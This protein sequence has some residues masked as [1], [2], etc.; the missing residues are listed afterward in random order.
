[1]DLSRRSLLATL[2]AAAPLVAVPRIAF[3]R[4]ETDQR[5]VLIILRG[6][7]DG[8]GAVPPVGDPHYR[9]ARGELAQQGPAMIDGMFAFHPALEQTAAMVSAGEGLVV[10]AV[11]SPYRDRSHF[12]GQNVLE[13]GGTSPYEYKDGW[14]NRLLPLLPAGA[15]ALAVAPAVPPVL[16]GRVGVESYAPSKL[17]DPTQD[18]LDRVALLYRDDAQLHALWDRAIAA[19]TTAQGIDGMKGMSAG[20]GANALPG[21]AKIAAEFL[22]RPGGVRV[23]VME[24][25]GWDTH[26]GQAGRLANQL[27]QLDQC[28]AALKAGLGPAWANTVVVAATEFGRTVQVNGTGGT[29]HGTASAAFVLGGAVKGGHVLAD[30][31]GLAQSARFEGRDLKPTTDLRALLLAASAKHL[32]IDPTRAARALFP[33]APGLKPAPV[34][35]AG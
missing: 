19:R 23:A 1:M 33:E 4:A 14:L 3:A 12:D 27:R 24:A 9:S 32:G 34:L 17:P 31:P 15:H 20:A 8:L 26:S 11:A 29:D 28:F 6:A 16:R 25:D 2:G 35:R 30:W 7:M 13:T 5:F 10:H 22:S 21:L 18:Y